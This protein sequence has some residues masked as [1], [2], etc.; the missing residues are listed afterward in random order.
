MQCNYLDNFNKKEGFISNIC[1]AGK[2]YETTEE[3]R[4]QYCIGN[5]FVNCPRFEAILR[6]NES[7]NCI[8]EDE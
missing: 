3:D 8:E 4:K 6:I 7:E 2:K 1:T 5:D